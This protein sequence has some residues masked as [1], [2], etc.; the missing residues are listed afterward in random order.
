M[1]YNCLLNLSIFIQDLKTRSRVF[2]YFV[3]F[4][5]RTTICSPSVI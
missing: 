5:V 4:C 2:K 1:A 3:K